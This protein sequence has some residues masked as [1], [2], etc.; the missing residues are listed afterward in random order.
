MGKVLVEASKVTCGAAPPHQG[1]IGMTGA[2]RLVVDG[3]KVLTTASVRG[4]ATKT[5]FPGCTN[6]GDSSAPCTKIKTMSGG[7]STRL[8]V[9]GEFVVL[10]SLDATTDKASTVKVHLTALNNDRLET[11]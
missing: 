8:N 7:A 4:P 11:E 6:P 5:P 9:D 3:S 10:D 1:S 2:A